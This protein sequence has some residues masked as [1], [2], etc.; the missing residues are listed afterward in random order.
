MHSWWLLRITG[1]K[2]DIRAVWCGILLSPGTKFVYTLRLPMYS[3]TLLSRGLCW[4]TTVPEWYLHEPYPCYWMRRLSSSL[5]RWIIL[6]VDIWQTVWNK[7]T[8]SLFHNLRVQLSLIF[9]ILMTNPYRF[10]VHIAQQQVS[11]IISTG[12]Y[13]QEFSSLQVLH[14]G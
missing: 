11:P 7:K 4:T 2:P 14:F 13:S 12:I 1:T 8:Q 3:W 9:L 6:L 10:V 5:V